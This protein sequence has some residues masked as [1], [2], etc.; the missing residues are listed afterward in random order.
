M[1]PWTPTGTPVPPSRLGSLTPI[2]DLI[3]FDG[4]LAF[5]VRDGDSYLRLVWWID[6]LDHGTRYLATRITGQR[7]ADLKGNR[8]TCRAAILANPLVWIIDDM[9]DRSLSAVE[10][11]RED[12]PEDCLP[13]VG[14]MLA[15]A[16]ADDKERHA[17]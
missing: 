9:A 17:C 8:L 11:P 5:T 7:L 14:V 4:P 3:Y 1:T 13:V 12:V 6:Q 15:A 10:I 16:E 2:D